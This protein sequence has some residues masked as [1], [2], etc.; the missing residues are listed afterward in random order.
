MLDLLPWKFWQNNYLQMLSLFCVPLGQC[1]KNH[2]HLHIRGIVFEAALPSQKPEST[3]ATP[4]DSVL[5]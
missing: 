1:L 2:I 5:T 4:P 3:H